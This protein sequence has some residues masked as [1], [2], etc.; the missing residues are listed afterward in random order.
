[1]AGSYLKDQK[2]TIP[3]AAWLTG[4]YGHEGLYMGVPVTIGAGGVERVIEIELN[5]DEK[6]LLD[7]SAAHVRELMKAA[8]TM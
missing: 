3:C 8:E 1:M 4:Q 7:K 2:R 5:A 6:A